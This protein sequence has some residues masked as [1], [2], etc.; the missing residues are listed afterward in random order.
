[1]FHHIQ[2]EVVRDLLRA[3]LTPL[4]TGEKGSGKTTII[5]QAAEELELKFYSISMTR[6]TTLSSLIGFKNING[7]YVSTQLREAVEFGGVLLLDEIDAGDPNVLLCFNTIENGFMSFPDKRIEVHKDFRLCATANPQSKH[8]TGRA[9]LDAATMDRFDDIA[10]PTDHA[11]EIKLVGALVADE[12]KDMR[13]LLQKWNMV[14]RH[15]SMRDAIR[16]KKRRDLE[17]TKGFIEKLLDN[18]KEMMREYEEVRERKTFIDQS[19]CN[20][21]TTLMKNIKKSQGIFDE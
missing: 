11:L 8:H 13:E 20:D 12:I 5:M 16:L 9:K 19:E 17:L 1:M 6:Q 18:N 15:I 14:E 2:Y 10:L 3:N 4:L 7:D 21:V